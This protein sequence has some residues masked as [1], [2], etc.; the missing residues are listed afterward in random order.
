MAEM[1]AF[2]RSQ[3][4]PLAKLATAP[5]HRVGGDYVRHYNDLSREEVG[6]L[7]SCTIEQLDGYFPMGRIRFPGRVPRFKLRSEPAVRFYFPAGWATPGAGG[8]RLADDV[9]GSAEFWNH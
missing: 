8:S 3:R 5:G 1:L 4:K 2:L 6:S 7:Q 9:P